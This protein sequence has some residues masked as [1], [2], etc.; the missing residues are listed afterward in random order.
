[1]SFSLPAVSDLPPLG[2]SVALVASGFLRE[3]ATTR[4]RRDEPAFVDKITAFNAS[5]LKTRRTL[6]EEHE[7]I[8]VIRVEGMLVNALGCLDPYWGMTGYDGIQAKLSAAVD[9]PDIRGVVLL[10]RSGGGEVSGCADTAEAIY[11]ARAAKPI[12]AIL[13]DCAYSAAYWLAAAAHSIAVPGTG[14]VGSIGAVGLH[15]DMSKALEK[16]GLGVTVLRA[17][18]R[19]AE[20]LPYEALSTDAQAAW[21]DEL[22]AIRALFVGSVARYR[23]LSVDALMATEAR[24]LPVITGEALRHRLADAIASPSQA[25]R[26][27]ADHT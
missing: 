4:L 6:F 15:I 22:V 18:A 5:V 3:L 9:D 17:G 8:A 14:G 27:F 19:K 10:V 26:A 24:T 13:D 21:L 1:M 23:S 12:V 25:W 20:T 11:R 16:S 2:P 7:G